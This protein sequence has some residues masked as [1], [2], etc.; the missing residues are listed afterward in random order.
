MR[1]LL[2]RCA[3]LNLGSQ[4]KYR[5]VRQGNNRINFVAQM[6]GQGGVLET[7]V[8]EKSIV[9]KMFFK[10]T[11]SDAVSCAISLLLRLST[12]PAFSPEAWPQISMPGCT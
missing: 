9:T 6:R 10:T 8:A 12:F 4:S 7:E 5:T 2:V 1:R 3:L 11:P